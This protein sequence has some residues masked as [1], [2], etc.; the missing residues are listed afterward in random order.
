MS[1]KVQVP[2]DGPKRPETSRAKL[3]HLL[4]AEVSLMLQQGFS[5]ASA[6]SKEQKGR[7]AVNPSVNTRVLNNQY[8][9]FFPLR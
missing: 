8:F 3:L 6:M 4:G 5:S 1:V 2:M 9:S 7:E